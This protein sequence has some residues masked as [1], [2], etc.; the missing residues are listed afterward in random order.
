MS[1]HNPPLI[2][3]AHQ[4]LAWNAL[5]FQ[6]DYT[7]AVAETRASEIGADAP[8]RNGNTLLG[9]P[10]YLQARVAVIFASLYASPKRRQ[11]DDWELMVYRT[12]AEAHALY[13]RQLDYYHRL[14][15]EQRQFHL[16]GDQGDL[17]EVLASW[18]MSPGP[19]NT[20]PRL[21]GLV[22]LMEGADAIREPAEVEGWMERGV[23]VVGLAWAGTRYAGGTGEPGPLTDDGRRLLEV[24]HGLGL[25]LDLAHC[26]DQALIEAVDRF[27]GVLMC[28]H[29]NPRA[30]L[31]RPRY[32]ERHLSD[33]AIRLI[34]ERGG[35]M[36]IVPVN[37]F[38]KSDWEASQG[39]S[40][41]TLDQVAAAMDHV[42]QLTGSAAH[43]GLGTDFD[44]GFGL[45]AT[46]AE[47]DSIADLPKLIPLLAAR[48]YSPEQI[49]AM[50]GGNWL[51][52][53]RRGLPGR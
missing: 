16:I 1:T 33:T 53:L 30:L 28:T 18:E 9:L 47:I 35:V 17:N 39:K 50:L 15:D 24:M 42:C 20:D 38:L 48:G 52:V 21:V 44:G 7:R 32:P 3:D 5:S 29:A 34:A 51:R 22:P 4:D 49:A 11:L 37:R 23:R 8:R 46:P 13:S 27:E 26:S 12:Q 10:E 6:R 40:A 25:M 41:V 14:T 36:G 43:V 45:E 31:K 19:D 2:V